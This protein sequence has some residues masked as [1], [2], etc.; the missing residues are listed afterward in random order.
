M[1]KVDHSPIRKPHQSL[2]RLRDTGEDEPRTRRRRAASDVQATV[3]SGT[4]PSDGT[5][6]ELSSARA[7][8]GEAESDRGARLNV[9]VHCS[10]REKARERR[11]QIEEHVRNSVLE[12]TVRCFP[13]ASLRVDIADDARRGSSDVHLSLHLPRRTLC[14]SI[15]DAKWHP[16]F[17]RA[18]RSLV[19]SVA[20]Y[21][22]ELSRRHRYADVRE[23]RDKTEDDESGSPD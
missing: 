1:S 20:A 7:D 4:P 17:V 10:Q 2:P 8:R 11:Q 13:R 5:L 14:A 22:S 3:Q 15:S 21:K 23:L 19:R 18:L 12:R 9:A 16:A 6:D